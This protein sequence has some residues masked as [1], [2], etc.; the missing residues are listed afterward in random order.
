MHSFEHYKI[1][2]KLGQGAM[3]VVYKAIDTR[4][5]RPVAL[6]VVSIDL[7]ESERVQ[8]AARLQL[9]ARAA[10]KLNHPNIITIYECGEVN[11][12]PYIAMEFIDGPTLRELLSSGKRLSVDKVLKITGQLLKGVAYAHQNGI[13]HRDIKPANLMFTSNGVLK[14]TDFG[15]AKV[16][17]SNMTHTDT[18]LGSP[19]YMS[20]EQLSG[21]VVDGRS[22]IFSVGSVLYEMLAGRPPFDSDNVASIVYQILFEPP[23]SLPELNGEVPTWLDEAVG[24]CLAKSPAE[25]FQTADELIELLK[26]GRREARLADTVVV[27]PEDPPPSPLVAGPHRA[28]WGLLG[29]AVVALLAGGVWLGTAIKAPS[30]PPVQTSLVAPAKPDAATL[31]PQMNWSDKGAVTLKTAPPSDVAASEPAKEEKPH[32]PVAN[33]KPAPAVSPVKHSPKGATRAGQPAQ[34]DGS[35]SARVPEAVERSH[36]SDRG[37]LAKHAEVPRH[38]ETVKPADKKSFWEKQVDCLK[39]GL[40]EQPVQRRQSAK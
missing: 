20:P 8:F 3:G 31:S 22:D 12:L 24:C 19:R 1:I 23:P 16:S 11:G 25:R 33:D 5:E 13:V 18:L 34:D 39:E 29:G 28:R 7:D 10:A 35:K 40:C 36:D 27:Q 32:Q 30:V 26:Q 37:E 15:I 9:E 4:L 14:I 21:K 38:A 17:A 6:K 2:G